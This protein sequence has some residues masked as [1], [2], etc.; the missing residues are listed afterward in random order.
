MGASQ[1]EQDHAR[2]SG[3]VIRHWLAPARL[4]L[5]GDRVSGVRFEYTCFDDDGNLKG[6]GER[7]ELDAD[8]VFKAIGQNVLWDAMGDT[9]DSLELERGR[10]GV[11]DHR[12]TSLADVWAGGDCIAGGKDLTVSAVQDGKL[13]AMDIDRFLRRQ[14]GL[15]N[16][17]G[18]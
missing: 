15:K 3:V 4:L 5:S 11:D 17:S 2:T 1:L 18:E 14:S 6:T 10:I 7:C 8:I 16:G 9:A 13:A 12:K